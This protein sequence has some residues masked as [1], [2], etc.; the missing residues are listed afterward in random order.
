MSRTATTTLH[1]SLPSG[2]R[3]TIGERPLGAT[4]AMLLLVIWTV[5]QVLA[6]VPS[7]PLGLRQVLLPAKAFI[8]PA[9]L[10]G[11]GVMAGFKVRILP[12]YRVLVFFTAVSVVNLLFRSKPNW[13]Q[14]AVFVAWCSCFLLAPQL[15]STRERV[16]TYA[17]WSLWGLSGA[18]I[19]AMVMGLIDDNY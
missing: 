8:G 18:M 4:V 12:P 9:V 13:V 14:A 2:R 15:L 1:T 17:R 6:V 3:E 11:I 5:S 7:F 19:T 16:K 10:L